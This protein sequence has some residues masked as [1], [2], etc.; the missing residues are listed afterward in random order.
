MMA[1][2][3]LS[4]ALQ[5]ASPGEFSS[6]QA[7]I[8]RASDG[9]VIKVPPGRYRERIDFRGKSL[10]I[11]AWDFAADRPGTP[12]DHIIEA[13]REGPVVTMAARML[14]VEGKRIE[15]VLEGFTVT[16]GTA[17]RGAGVYLEGPVFA[18]IYR[19]M[20]TG[21]AALGVQEPEEGLGGG[22][23]VD[24]TASLTLLSSLVAGNVS[25]GPGGGV[26]VATAPIVEEKR[27]RVSLINCT[28][29]ANRSKG[30]AVNLSG[31]RGETCLVN[32]IIWGNAGGDLASD[33]DVPASCNLFGSAAG[34]VCAERCLFV[35]PLF[36][37][38][39]AADFRLTRRSPARNAG[40]DPG[41]CLV[42][43]FR[44]PPEYSDITGRM[45]EGE[46]DMGVFEYFEI[47]VRADVNQN[48]DGAE[49]GDAISILDY[50]FKGAPNTCLD[51][52]DSNDDG[53]ADLSD[54]IYILIYYF[55]QGP[56]PPPPFPEPGEDLTPDD[57]DCRLYLPGGGL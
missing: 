31:L 44:R 47:F 33:T 48:G 55:L 24:G 40:C 16:G 2:L 32:N 38:F 49:L 57:L 28:V 25:E 7:A 43:P 11:I 39:D 26:Y 5:A 46:R 41:A 50:L 13:P 18:E 17:P 22:V 54:A 9:E 27:G 8:D 4:F 12:L 36:A 15:M 51:S 23:Y 53:R 29:T 21:N 45:P 30:P 37:A 34:V 20:I 10:K 42:R 1:A 14:P 52:T 56:P 19:C 6:I 3:I 35:D